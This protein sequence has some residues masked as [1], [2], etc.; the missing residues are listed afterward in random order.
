MVPVDIGGRAARARLYL[1]KRGVVI[2]RQ[3]RMVG[4]ALVLVDG[5]VARAGGNAGCGD[6]VADA[7][8]NLH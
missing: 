7:A 2:D 4:K 6:L 8:K 3:R 1:S 5:H